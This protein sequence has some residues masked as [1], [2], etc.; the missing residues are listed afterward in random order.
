MNTRRSSNICVVDVPMSAGLGSF[1]PFL[2]PKWRKKP[3]HLHCWAPM[4]QY[5]EPLVFNF[6][7]ALPFPIVASKCQV[8]ALISPHGAVTSKR[9]RE[10]P[11]HNRDAKRLGKSNH[12]LLWVLSLGTY[13][14]IKNGVAMQCNCMT[15][16]PQI[17]HLAC[18]LDSSRLNSAV[19]SGPRKQRTA[20]KY[21]VLG[22]RMQH[23]WI[24]ASD[25]C[26]YVQ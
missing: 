10:K 12:I 26:L 21:G 7:G 4:W 16:R 18:A 22:G 14:R 8:N 9:D 2:D 20:W 6:Q 3:S 1:N 5:W 19:F 23:W 17:P 25:I 24:G 15:N 13:V 11:T